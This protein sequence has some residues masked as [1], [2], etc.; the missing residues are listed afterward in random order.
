MLKQP[1]KTLLFATSLMFIINVNAA[2]PKE[3]AESEVPEWQ[4][5]KTLMFGD[6]Y[7]RTGKQSAITLSINPDIDDASTVPIHVDGLVNQ[8]DQP[9][10]K[11]LHI[12]VDQNPIPTAAVF[13]LSPS[14]GNLHLATRLRIEKYTFVRAVA[15]TSDGQLHMDYKWVAVK[16]G[17]SAPSGKNAGSDPLLGKMKVTFN[18]YRN[19]YKNENGEKVFR[20]PLEQPNVVKVQVRHPNESALAV[21]LDEAVSPNF[22]QELTVGFADEN[23]LSAQVNF[24]ISDNPAFT[25]SFSPK[26]E[27]DLSLTVK[28]THE[29]T[30]TQSISVVKAKKT[31]RNR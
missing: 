1:I 3:L 16:G 14:A 9:Y 25:F 22:I 4:T 2:D 13:E 18:K 27:G 26:R 5:I 6:R 17:C 28:D 10:I 31:G 24:S 30:F 21:D 23:V 15:E 11:T 8:K 20:V 12:I 7:I 29:N 19:S